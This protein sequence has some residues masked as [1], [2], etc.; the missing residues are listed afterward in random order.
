MTN[1]FAY[2]QADGSFEYETLT[3][4]QLGFPKLKRKYVAVDLFAEHMFNNNWYGKLEYTWSRNFGN[5]E[6]Q[7]L[8]DIDVGSGGQSDVSQTQD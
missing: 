3:T 5:T 1:T 8:S 4:E 2:E 7:L 6:G